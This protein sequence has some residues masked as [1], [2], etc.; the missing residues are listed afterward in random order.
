MVLVLAGSIP[1]RT[2]PQN[3]DF[4]FCR[5]LETPGKMQNRTKKQGKSKSESKKQG[6]KYG[7][8]YCQ[9]E[10]APSKNRPSF[11]YSTPIMDFKHAWSTNLVSKCS[12]T[13]ARMA[14]TPLGARQGTSRLP[15]TPYKGVQDRV[16][17]G[18]LGG[19]GAAATSLR[20]L[21]HLVY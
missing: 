5:T 21:G 2:T 9:F 4:S 6:N 13:P 16:R 19:G 18:P 12:A 15:A 10:P 11:W 7:Q 14:A 8:Q 3:K 17:Q 20:H 1:R